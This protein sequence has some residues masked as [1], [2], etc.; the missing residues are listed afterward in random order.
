MPMTEF[1]KLVA[2]ATLVVTHAGA[3]TLIH[4]LA[5]G[6]RPVVMPRRS[7][8]GEHIDGHQLEL[9]EAFAALGRIVLAREPI[10]L[11]AA[12]TD[13]LARAAEPARSRPL[14]MVELISDRLATY[15]RELCLGQ[16]AKR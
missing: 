15:E 10:D 2:D 7:D 9:A 1:T 16:R 14:R 3:G 4:A 6:K 13:A 11:P 5:A 8:L 12:I